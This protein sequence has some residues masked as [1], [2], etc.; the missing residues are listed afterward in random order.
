MSATHLLELSEIVC[1]HRYELKELPDILGNG[2]VREMLLIH[3]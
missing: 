2:S 1:I 3:I